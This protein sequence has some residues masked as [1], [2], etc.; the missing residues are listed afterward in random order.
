MCEQMFSN[1]NKTAVFESM[2]MCVCVRDF[3]R[4]T[5][6]I[7]SHQFIYVKKIVFYLSF[8]NKLCVHYVYSLL[9]SVWLFVTPWLQPARLLCPWNSPGKNSGVDC[10][11]HLQGIFPTQRSKLGLQNFRQIL[12]CLSHQKSPG[13]YFT[14]S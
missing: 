6:S 11:S 5:Y 14:W 4:K 9:S 7:V 10:H 8:L 3:D 12:Y 13:I 2:C 1:E